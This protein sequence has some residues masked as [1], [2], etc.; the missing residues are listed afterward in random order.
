MTR[1]AWN[2]SICIK[3]VWPQHETQNT[4]SLQ[5]NSKNHG[6]DQWRGIMKESKSANSG[7]RRRPACTQTAQTAFFKPEAGERL[8]LIRINRPRSTIPHYFCTDSAESDFW[9]EA[10]VEESWRRSHRGESNLGSLWEVL[11]RHLGGIWGSRRPW[12]SRRLTR[13]DAPL[14]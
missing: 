13:T 2:Q 3:S 6:R 11:E 10:L 9:K 1:R 12:G 4:F 14:N 5:T 7:S 8:F